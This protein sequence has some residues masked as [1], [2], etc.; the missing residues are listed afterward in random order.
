MCV[1]VGL[2]C[3]LVLGDVYIVL[4]GQED[5]VVGVGVVYCLVCGGGVYQYFQMFVGYFGVEW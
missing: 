2:W 5:V 1:G 4:V 3:F